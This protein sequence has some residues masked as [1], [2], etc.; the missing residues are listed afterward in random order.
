MANQLYRAAIIVVA[1]A[2]LS[3]C[4]Q[5]KDPMEGRSNITTLMKTDEVTGTGHE[6]LP[7]RRVFVHYTGRDLRDA[8]QEPSAAYSPFVMRK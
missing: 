8:L 3:S 7:G 5:D 2:I 1:V 6:A 4:A